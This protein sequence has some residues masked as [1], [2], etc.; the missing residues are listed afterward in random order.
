L[1]AWSKSGLRDPVHETSRPEPPFEPEE[2]TQ[3]RVSGADG[4]SRAVER[5]GRAQCFVLSRWQ[6]WPATFFSA[7]DAAHSLHAA[8][9]HAV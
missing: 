3:A 7:D 4:T 8:V 6:E 9:V 2:D 1:R 5:A